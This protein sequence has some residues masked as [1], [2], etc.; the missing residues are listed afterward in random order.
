MDIKQKWLLNFI[1]SNSGIEHINIVNEFPW[2]YYRTGSKTMLD[3]LNDLEKRRLIK[4]SHGRYHFLT[5]NE[6]EG[7]FF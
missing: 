5:D 1:K 7:N 4:K 6:E 2:G 3:Y